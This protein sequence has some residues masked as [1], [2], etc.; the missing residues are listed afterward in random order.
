[1]RREPPRQTFSEIVRQA[2]A[3]STPP[4]PAHA[5]RPGRFNLAGELFTPEGIRVVRHRAS[6][7][8]ARAQALVDHGAALAHEGCGCGGWAGCA[9]VWFTG[10]ALEALRT[11]RPRLDLRTSAPTWID[12]WLADTATV[13]FTHGAVTWG[14]AL[15]A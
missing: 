14:D 5:V 4:G 13:V 15:G 9:P 8:P 1:M 3:T 11:S 7:S 6:V 12:V 2:H 10:T